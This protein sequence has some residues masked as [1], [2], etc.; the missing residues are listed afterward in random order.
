K[1]VSDEKFKK[2]HREENNIFIRNH[3]KQTGHFPE[4]EYCEEF[5]T[6]SEELIREPGGSS[7]VWCFESVYE[8]ELINK[9]T[10]KERGYYSRMIRILSDF[11]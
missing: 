10:E 7:H 11:S 9:F 2:I 4:C 5:I 1:E 3:V 6:K 8:G